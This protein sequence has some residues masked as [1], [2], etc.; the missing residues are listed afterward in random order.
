MALGIC[1]EVKRQPQEGARDAMPSEQ[2]G[3]RDTASP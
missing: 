3:G 1:G 2:G